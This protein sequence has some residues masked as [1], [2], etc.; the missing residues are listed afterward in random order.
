MSDINPDY[1]KM[2]AHHIPRWNNTLDEKGAMAIVLIGQDVQGQL[3]LM[4][5]HGLSNTETANML[6]SI[7]ATLDAENDIMLS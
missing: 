2:N 4:K 6:R 1:I 3:H 5:A 7:A